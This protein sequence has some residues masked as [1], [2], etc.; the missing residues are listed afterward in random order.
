[1]NGSLGPGG[2]QGAPTS[3]LCRAA[4]GW[5]ETHLGVLHGGSLHVLPA[6]YLAASLGLLC[7]CASAIT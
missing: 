4:L 3:C 6:P 2:D 7:Q 1:M 5:E